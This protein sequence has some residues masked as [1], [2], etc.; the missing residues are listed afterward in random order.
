MDTNRNNQY[1]TLSEATVDLK[2]RGYTFNFQINENGKLTDNKNL[3]F[4]PS[5]VILEEFH[6]FEGMTNPAD[7]TILYA[8]RT[9]SGMK[10]T[11]VDSYGADG[12]EITSDFMNK[13]QPGKFD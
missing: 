3:E 13:A 6:R 9:K 4:D 12:S 11:V 7:S 2:K 5:E 8:V 1:D 10:G